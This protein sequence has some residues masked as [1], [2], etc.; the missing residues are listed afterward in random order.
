[1]RAAGRLSAASDHQVVIAPPSRRGSIV[2]VPQSASQPEGETMKVRTSAAAAA[3]LGL[4]TASVLVLQ[5]R[6][7]G[8][9]IAFPDNYDK[10]VMYFSFDKPD[11][12]QFREIYV[13]PGA[14]AALN[15]G[16]AA[17]SGTVITQVLYKAKLDADGNPVKDANGHFIKT[18]IAAY[19]VMEKGTGWGAEYPPEKRNG[20][21]E[22]QVFTPEKKVNEKAN[23]AACFECHKPLASADFLFTADKIKAAAK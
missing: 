9:K 17:P 14:I 20:E 21:W 12:K 3:A 8:D 18:D 23:L 11:A 22:Y 19:A 13:T 6:A 1:M 4:V 15:K 16:E 7:G 2:V 10:G 5:V